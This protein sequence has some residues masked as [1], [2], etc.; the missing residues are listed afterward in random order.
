M[1]TS[2]DRI[3]VLKQVNKSNCPWEEEINRMFSTSDPLASDRHNHVAPVYDVLQSPLDKDSIVLVMPYLMRINGVRFATVG[4][5][6]ECIRQLF[7]VRRF[8]ICERVALLYH[9]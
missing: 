2:D 7:E 1:R 3:V 6:I 4:E 8:P 5:G 9:V